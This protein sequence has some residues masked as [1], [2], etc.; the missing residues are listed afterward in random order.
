MEATEKYRL[1]KRSAGETILEC[2]PRESSWH[3]EFSFCA[4]S[5]PPSTYTFKQTGRSP[6]AC[7]NLRG[8]LVGH[9]TDIKRL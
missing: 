1:G 4:P 6:I 7:F 2:F 3:A 9:S 5:L 8:K